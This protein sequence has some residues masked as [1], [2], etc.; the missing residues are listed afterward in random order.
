VSG[1]DLLAGGLDP[2]LR[3]E[4][5][6]EMIARDLPGY[7]VG[8]L[9][10]GEE[11]DAFWRVV[12]QST[13]QPGGLPEHKPRYCMGVGYTSDI[14]VCCA[15]GIDMFDCVFPT[16]TAR[17]GSA[18][19]LEG[20]LQLKKSK[21]ADDTRPIDPECRC[22]TCQN[23]TRAY[24]HTVAAREEVGCHLVS[25]HNIAFMCRFMASLRQSI[26]DGRFPDFVRGFF[27]AQH[28][29]GKYPGWCVD[30]LRDAGIELS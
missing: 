23:Y 13:L 28:P 12:S 14:V 17:F 10:G 25:I 24:L 7:A 22:Y 8:G 11:K 4:C 9:S 3:A 26:V 6:K 27:R 29:D 18:L 19:V 15:L 21:Y 1:P 2:V 16:R 20:Q 30:A 5:L